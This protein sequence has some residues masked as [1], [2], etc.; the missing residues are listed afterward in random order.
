M[1]S[2]PGLAAAVT[3]RLPAA[4][5]DSA[6]DLAGYASSPALHHALDING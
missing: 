2:D 4:R 1:A 5:R 3:A 6:I